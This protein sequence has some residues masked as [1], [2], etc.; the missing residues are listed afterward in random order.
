MYTHT[1]TNSEG[2]RLCQAQKGKF[3]IGKEMNI[4]MNMNNMCQHGIK[5]F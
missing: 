5:C 1:L 4:S 3:G 2:V